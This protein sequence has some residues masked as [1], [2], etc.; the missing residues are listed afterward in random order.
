MIKYEIKPSVKLIYKTVKENIIYGDNPIL[1]YIL[2]ENYNYTLQEILKNTNW[3]KGGLSRDIQ[4]GL[5]QMKNPIKQL[6]HKLY[7]EKIN[8]KFQIYIGS[9]NKELLT[10]TEIKKD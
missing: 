8:E 5:I 7:L 10:L 6:H 2:F 1:A 9:I 4:K 3:E